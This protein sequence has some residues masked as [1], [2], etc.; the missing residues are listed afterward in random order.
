MVALLWHGHSSR[1]DFIDPEQLIL[2]LD[3]ED[4]DWTAETDW[5]QVASN[6][7]YGLGG[8]GDEPLAKLRRQAEELTQD[9]VPVVRADWFVVALTRPPLAGSIGLMRRPTSEVPESMRTLAHQYAAE[10]LDL[11]MCAHELGLS[12]PEALADL[13]CRQENLRQEFGLAP[14]L[15]GDRIRRE[16]WETIR[17]QFLLALPGTGPPPENSASPFGCGMKHHHGIETALYSWR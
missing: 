13:I 2:R 16:W 5:H 6:Y 8:V 10:T 3:L 9:S 12:N 11:A 14:L 15:Q 17:P 4:L 7:C 1:L